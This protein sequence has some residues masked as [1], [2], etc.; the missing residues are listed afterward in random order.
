MNWNSYHIPSARKNVKASRNESRHY[1]CICIKRGSRG[2]PLT[3]NSQYVNDSGSCTYNG[4]Q[5]LLE[6]VPRR[7]TINNLRGSVRIS[8]QTGTFLSPI[9]TILSE[10][11]VDT[12]LSYQLFKLQLPKERGDEFCVI[13]NRP[14]VLFPSRTIIMGILCRRY[15]LI[16]TSP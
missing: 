5:H 13:K 14:L 8:V 9:G 11:K 7:P 15:G 10:R 16:Q 6:T 2:R 3:E 12:E 4:V 1:L